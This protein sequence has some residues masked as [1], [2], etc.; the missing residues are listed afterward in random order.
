MNKKGGRVQA[1]KE[2]SGSLSRIRS[3]RRS[4]MRKKA[5]GAEG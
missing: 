5:E 2:S 1:K 3:S 4:R